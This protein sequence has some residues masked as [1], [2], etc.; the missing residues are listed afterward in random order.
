[1]TSK[2]DQNLRDTLLTNEEKVEELQAKPEEEK[3]IPPAPFFSL[4]R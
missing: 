2:S 1:M 4:F 3:V